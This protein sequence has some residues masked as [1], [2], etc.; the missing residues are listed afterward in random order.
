RHAVAVTCPD[1]DMSTFKEFSAEASILAGLEKE[2]LRFDE[3]VAPKH[4]KFG[5][6]NVKE[7]QTSEEEWLNNTEISSSFQ[8]FLDL[9]GKRIKLQGYTCYAA[10]LDTK[11]GETG[12]YSYISRWHNQEIMFHVPSL[13]PWREQDKQQIH[14][15]RH[16]GNDIVSLVFVEGNGKFDPRAIRSQFLHVFVVVHLDYDKEGNEQ[17]FIEVVHHPNVQPFGP[18]I[19]MASQLST[20][21]LRDFLLLKSKF[22]CLL[23][24]FMLLLFFLYIN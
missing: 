4:Y 16:I 18:I 17:W 10:G 1:L 11:S 21:Q 7:N 6:L 3:L 22:F 2:L 9:I 15:K 13:M 14:R 5:V 23:L 12:E 20:N 19:P 24:F 8:R